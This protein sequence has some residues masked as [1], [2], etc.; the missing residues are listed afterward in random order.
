MENGGQFCEY[1][2]GQVAKY[3][4][5]NGKW[6]C[7][8]NIA[9]CPK[10]GQKLSK[11]I[12]EVWTNSEIR[13]KY[14]RGMV[15]AWDNPEVKESRLQAIKESFDKSEVKEKRSK[16]AKEAW[17]RQDVKDRSSRAQKENQNKPEVKMK[18][19]KSQLEFWSGS[20]AK[21]KQSEIIRE[22]MNRPEV[23]EKHRE[24]MNRPEVKEKI[25][26]ASKE[27][28]NKPE[29]KEKRRQKMLNGQA[30]FMNSKIRNPSK[31][32]G[33]LYEKAEDLYEDAILNY[34]LGKYSLDIGVVSIK[35]DIEYDGSY[36]HQD[37]EGDEKRQKEIEDKGWKVLRYK[38]YVPTLEQLREDILRVLSL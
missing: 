28:M 2:C 30:V 37:R 34:Q 5:K 29:E 14:I 20:G 31:P 33:E 35:L 24:A 32:Q 7:S 19:L 38:D 36:W 21:E 1:G 18:K 9:S 25:A 15:V 6:C 13:E 16:S 27:A 12:Q 17:D 3:R 26:I 22:A 11:S 23:K 8:K 4:F 10:I